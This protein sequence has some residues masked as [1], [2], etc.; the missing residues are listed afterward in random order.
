M[1]RDI[2]HLDISPRYPRRYPGRGKW[3]L[4]FALDPIHLGI[5][6]PNP[7]WCQVWP[8][9]FRFH[10]ST[11]SQLLHTQVQ[12][13]SQHQV[14]AYRPRHQ[15][16]VEIGSRLALTNSDSRPIALGFNQQVYPS[17]F[18]PQAHSP[19][20]LGIRPVFLN[21]AAERPPSD[22]TRQWA[23][24]AGWWKTFLD[25]ASLQILE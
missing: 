21:T 23:G 9:S 1:K 20:D 10:P 25:K 8:H 5:K 24:W 11:L 12:N 19:A 7:L 4:N 2:L 22:Y 3:A 13:L 6:P 14:N 16:S 18:W 17:G 15:A